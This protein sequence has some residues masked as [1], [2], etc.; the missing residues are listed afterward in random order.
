MQKSVETDWS[1]WGVKRGE[2]GS[3]T[4]MRFKQVLAPTAMAVR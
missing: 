2:I 3:R 4:T 1:G